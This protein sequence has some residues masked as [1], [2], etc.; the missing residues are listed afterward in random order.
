MNRKPIYVEIDIQAEMDD[1]W[2]ASQNP[3][4]HSQWDLRFSSITYL[5]KIEDE[6]QAFTYERRVAPLLTIKGWGKSIGSK[7]NTNRS[8]SSSLHFG[9]KQWF[10]PI[11]EGRGYWKYEPL[12]NGVKFLTQ[13]DYKVNFSALGK[14]VDAFTF[15]PMMGWATAL[16]FD[17]MKRW[18]EKGEAPHSQYIRFFTTYGLTLFFAL[19]W[20][21]QGLIPK[22]IATHP[23]ELAMVESAFSNIPLQASSIVIIIGIAE[24]LF[25]ALWLF[26]K[27][28][29]HLFALQVAVFPLLTIAAI[30]VAPETTAHPFNPVMFNLALIALSL[31][32]YFG[33]EDVPTAKSCKRKR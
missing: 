5:P 24:I 10:S 27:K 29:K 14:L 21:Y 26:Y 1:V 8:Q 13:Y 9:S 12:D 23:E 6:P 17:V 2:N 18:I 22:I 25:G 15:R 31:I 33:S 32:G 30:I 3:E 19:L 4:L 16:S 7:T 20:I 28:K 11:R